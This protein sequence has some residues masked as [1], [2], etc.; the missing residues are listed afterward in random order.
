MTTD[1][2]QAALSELDAA[3][4]DTALA[5]DLALAR[6]ACADLTLRVQRQAR[7]IERLRRLCRRL[8]LSI[9]EEDF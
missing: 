8:R 9:L 1:E 5:L 3:E 6:E 2:N 4:N 7:E